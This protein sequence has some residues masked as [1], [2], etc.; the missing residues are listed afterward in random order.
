MQANDI[1]TPNVVT[2]RPEMPVSEIAELLVLNKI[3]AVPV[4]DNNDTLVG[5]IS[6]GDLLRRLSSSAGDDRPWW[7]KM[8]SSQSQDASEFIKVHGR[9]A[10]DVMTRNLITVDETAELSE[11][12]HTLETHRIKR[13]PVVKDGK[14]VGIVS[15]SN[16]L[17]A[18]AGKKTEVKKSATLSDRDIRQQVYKS[19]SEQG[20][21]SHGSMNVMVED[22]I[23]ELWGW[24][25]SETERKA[26]LLA[27][28]EI[29]GVKDVRDH[30]GKISPWVWGT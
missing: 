15:R 11:V 10:Q 7:V 20:F 18:V 25:E 22:G 1:M 24:V 28:S 23:V 12:A 26:L 30:F 16:L 8:M 17:Q 13:V 3:S 6:E 9:T 29:P 2:V 19:L 4:V 14:I 27:A 5:I 21:A